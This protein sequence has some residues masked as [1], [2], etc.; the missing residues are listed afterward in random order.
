MKTKIESIIAAIE[1]QQSEQSTCQ[2]RIDTL[3]TELK[4]HLATDDDLSYHARFLALRRQAKDIVDV[5]KAL[6]PMI[7]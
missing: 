7:K 5:A 2:R 6:E 3:L 4:K 1:H